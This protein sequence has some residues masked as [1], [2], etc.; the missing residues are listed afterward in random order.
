MELLSVLT[1][2]QNVLDNCSAND[3]TLT[4]ESAD[5]GRLFAPASY[6]NL[7]LGI[8]YAAIILNSLESKNV[9][10]HY[11]HK[12]LT[13]AGLQEAGLTDFYRPL[14][15]SED[16]LGKRFITI[17]EA[18]NYP[19]YGVQFH[20]EKPAFEFVVKASQQR[21]PHSREAIA[22]SRYFAD[23]FVQSAQINGHQASGGDRRAKELIYAHEP[24]YTG[25]MNDMYEE[26]YLFPYKSDG[27]TQEEF[28]DFVPDDDY[29]PPENV[30]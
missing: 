15:Y 25:L 11:H 6:A 9:T 2:E 18:I 5:R 8:D 27:L 21:I 26:R 19:F 24:M 16:T 13:D 14:A 23:F 22:V 29:E 10:Y 3:V 28:L 7:P 12:C 4:V 17:F 30:V 1:A 20:P